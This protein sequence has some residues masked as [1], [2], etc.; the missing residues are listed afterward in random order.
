MVHPQDSVLIKGK[1]SPALAPL[2]LRNN[3]HADDPSPSDPAKNHV[4]IHLADRGTQIIES[5]GAVTV[6]KTAS[7][8]GAVNWLTTP[9]QPASTSRMRQSTPKDHIQCIWRLLPARNHSSQRLPLWPVEAPLSRVVFS[10]KASLGDC[11]PV[12]QQQKVASMI[13]AACWGELPVE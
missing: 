12:T 9:R 7:K 8:F 1:T 5:D 6:P 10:K 3:G 4:R 13:P 11:C 2:C